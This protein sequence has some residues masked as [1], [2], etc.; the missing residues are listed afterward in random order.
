M[1]LSF[2]IAETLIGSAKTDPVRFK[3][4]FGE[5]FV[6]LEI[7]RP[8]RIKQ[9]P[10]PD[11]FQNCATPSTVGTISFFGRSPSMEQPELVMKFLTVLGAPLILDQQ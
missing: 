8:W 5:D 7:P 1:Y 3:W 6:R 4:G 2:S 11:S 10:S 9:I